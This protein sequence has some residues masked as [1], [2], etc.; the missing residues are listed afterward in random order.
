MVYSNALF[1]N[2]DVNLESLSASVDEAESITDPPTPTPEIQ[3]SDGLPQEITINLPGLVSN[4]TPLQMVLIPAGSF[5]MGSPESE[6]GRS[7]DE[8]Q[9]EVVITKPFYMGKYEIT[10]AHWGALMGM[11]D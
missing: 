2:N 9:H 1:K 6:T 4:A 3:P 7:E 5:M 8:T 10:N 11:Y